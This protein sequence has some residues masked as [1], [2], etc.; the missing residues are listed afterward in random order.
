MNYEEIRVYGSVSGLGEA[1]ARELE[2]RYNLLVVDNDG[3][4][5]DFEFEGRHFFLDDFLEEL[6]P[7]LGPDG[8]GKVDYI[9]QHEW[10]LSRY[11]LENGRWAGKTVSLND[12]LDERYSRE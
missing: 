11:R 10:T 9:D 6:L 2:E 8:A 12:M 5:L 7:L 4:T 3:R 1:A